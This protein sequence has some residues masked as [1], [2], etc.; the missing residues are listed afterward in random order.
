M[1]LQ[2]LGQTTLAVLREYFASAGLARAKAPERLEIVAELPRNAT[3]KVLKHELRRIVDGNRSA[4]G[5]I[6]ASG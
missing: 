6:E 3:G 5:G 4:A 1:R 2:R